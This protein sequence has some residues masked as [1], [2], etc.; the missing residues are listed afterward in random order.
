[1]KNHNP[2][3]RFLITY[4]LFV[5]SLI[6]VVSGCQEKE[7]PIPQKTFTQILF[8]LHLAESYAQHL[9]KDTNRTTIK[10]AD[11]LDRYT[12]QI[13]KQYRFSEEQFHQT[14]DY[15]KSR[16]ILLDSIYQD[17]LSRISILQS[18]IK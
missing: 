4:A 16:P 2:I 14:L 13:L 17:M 8:D 15:Y 3:Y 10:N 1:M 7:P 5:A 18:K 9:P 11:S 6:L 12:A